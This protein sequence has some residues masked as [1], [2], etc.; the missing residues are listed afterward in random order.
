MSQS[1]A[2]RRGLLSSL[3]GAVN[4]T[5]VGAAGVGAAVAIGVFRS[6]PQV[7]AGAALLVAAAALSAWAVVARRQ[8]TETF[9]EMYARFL[10][11]DMVARV[12][13]LPS[14]PSAVPAAA[15]RV[16]HH[17]SALMEAGLVAA[18][19]PNPWAAGAAA[20]ASLAARKLR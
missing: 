3:P 1:A 11:D 15:P 14:P 8:R 5:I 2:P 13:A 17:A 6:N 7:A 10:E 20:A 16:R 18:Q 9:E 4:T 19:A 12:R